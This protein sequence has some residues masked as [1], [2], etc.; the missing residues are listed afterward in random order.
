MAEPNSAEPALAYLARGWSVIPVEPG[1]KRPLVRW[2]AFQNRLPAAAEVEA[3]RRR[4]PDANLAIVT[5]AV[6]GLAVLDVDPRH[7]ADESLRAL[8]QEHGPMPHTVEA[9]TGGGGRHLYFAH[10]GGVLRNKVGLAPGIDLR[11]DGGMV[12]APPSIHASGRPYAW[13]ISHHPDETRLA[14]MPAWLVTLARGDRDHP[15]QPLSHWRTLVR[16]GVSEGARNDTIASL[17][18]HLLWHEVDQEVVTEMLLCWNRV[19]CRPPLS[20]E[21]VVRTVKSIASTHAR[22]RARDRGAGS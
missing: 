2:E 8:K 22:Q 16:E 11:G 14:P 15:G 10:P 12:V 21:E 19:R 9:L 1:G 18:G 13:E 7:D 17:A 3:W 5:G 6:S 4:W 20:D